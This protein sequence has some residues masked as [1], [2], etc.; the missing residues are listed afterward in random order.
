MNQNQTT[1]NGSNFASVLKHDIEDN[2]S[3]LAPGRFPLN[4]FPSGI[5]KIILEY[6]RTLNFPIDYLGTSILYAT[7]LAIGNTYKA[8][9][10][11][12]FIVGAV[13]YCA[14]VGRPGTI[15]THPMNFALSPFL[16]RDEK[17]IAL[18]REE[19]RE[20]QEYSNLSKKDREKLGIEKKSPPI[21]RKFICS[22]FTPEALGEI[23]NFN[24]RGIGVHNDEL[25]GWTKNFNRYS[26][27]SEA[28]FWLQSW[29]S[30]PIV[31]DRKGGDK[32]FIGEPFISV[33]GSIQPGVLDTLSKDGRDQNGFMDRILFAYP[34]NMDKPAWNTEE[35][36]DVF[37]NRYERII[38]KIIGIPE[39]TRE[40][41]KFETDAR[42]LLFSWQKELA[43]QINES[44]D[45]LR[46]PLTK[47]ETY[48]IR[49]SLIVQL[50]RWAEG[51][52]N[53]DSI[54]KNS[55]EAALKLIAYFKQNAIKVSQHF[56]TTPA[57][58]LPEN[59]KAWYQVLPTNEFK[60]SDAIACGLGS[61]MSERNIK[62]YLDDR[63]L[64]RRMAHGRYIKIYA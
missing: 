31:I 45:F 36:N 38:S 20:F 28:E 8:E 16:K 59:I 24:R 60:T 54:D 6:N 63:T 22:D 1:Q 52:C 40:K 4:A 25:A 12:G 13:V 48:A 19:L 30:T 56:N 61:G 3:L 18:F 14:L 2:I 5:A 49:L 35:L 23:H 42:D 53:K 43:L 29:S 34:E 39:D 64:F 33:L 50:L 58:R 11:S 62:Y 15:K 17:S 57:E 46:G 44:P 47:L 21:Y 41:L 51:E 37:P 27:G 32:I 7:S 10:K 55:V 9:L 26:K